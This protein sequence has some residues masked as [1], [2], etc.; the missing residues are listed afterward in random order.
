[1]PTESSSFL[2]EDFVVGDFGSVALESVEVS[3]ACA[4]VGD[5]GA[6]EVEAVDFRG[7]G[8]GR[9]WCSEYNVAV[10]GSDRA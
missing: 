3:P 8:V 2:L 7:I 6:A 10:R 5:V 9:R 4:V 1:M